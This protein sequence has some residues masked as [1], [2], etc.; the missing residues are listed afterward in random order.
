[1]NDA[2]GSFE[3]STCAKRVSEERSGDLRRSR[4]TFRFSGFNQR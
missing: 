4:S 2:S 3:R 1:M